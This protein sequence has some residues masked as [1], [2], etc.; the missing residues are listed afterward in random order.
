MS[1]SER[2]HDLDVAMT[3]GPWNTRVNGTGEK[4]YVQMYFPG[5]HSFSTLAHSEENAAGI[6]ALRNILPYVQTL[7]EAA[8]DG[9]EKYIASS[10]VA[11]EVALEEWCEPRT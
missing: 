4:K 8:E 1:A 2:L 6:V 5:G 9:D 3:G 10:L 7:A 11:L